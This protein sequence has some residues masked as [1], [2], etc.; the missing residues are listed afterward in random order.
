M[1]IVKMV[2]NTCNPLVLL[3]IFFPFSVTSYQL[4]YLCTRGA[5]VGLFIC[6]LQLG[7]LLKPGHNLWTL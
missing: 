6:A 3:S 2:N 4:L 5:L 7:D 1:F